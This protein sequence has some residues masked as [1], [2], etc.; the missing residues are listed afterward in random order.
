MIPRH[1]F[2]KAS[3]LR[4]FL[5]F[6]LQ[7]V[8]GSVIRTEFTFDEENAY[9]VLSILDYEV[10]LN[11]LYS[12]HQIEI[13]VTEDAVLQNMCEDLKETI[14]QEYPHISAKDGIMVTE[15]RI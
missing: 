1:Q 2:L 15:I 12:H 3:L 14:E 8:T 13:A 6:Y 4:V 11:V 7:R 9:I 5:A 10:V